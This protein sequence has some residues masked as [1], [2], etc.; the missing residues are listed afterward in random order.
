MRTSPHVLVTGRQAFCWIAGFFAVIIGVN[1][2]MAILALSTFNGISEDQAY[3]DG[4]AFNETLQ[5][6]EAQLAL[7]WSVDAEINRP[8]ELAVNVRARYRDANDVA[9][10][11]L[12]IHAEFVRPVHQGYDFSVPLQQ[13]GPGLYTVT[14]QVPL[15]GQWTIRLIAEHDLSQVNQ[16]SRPYL[17][18]YRTVVR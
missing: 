13:V 11:N 14:T 10:S 16:T 15:A 12:K 1:A 4:L 3:V 6:V 18:T 9:L 5:A 17:L 7:G 8:G 2:T